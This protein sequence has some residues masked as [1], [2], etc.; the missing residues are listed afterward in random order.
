[1]EPKFIPLVLI[2]LNRLLG[3]LEVVQN[4]IHLTVDYSRMGSA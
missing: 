2:D 4:A 3:K 1:M